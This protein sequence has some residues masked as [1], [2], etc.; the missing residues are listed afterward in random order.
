L[1]KPVS[2]P[3]DP[4]T[5]ADTVILR[6]FYVV[7][8]ADLLFDLLGEPVLVARVVFDPDEAAKTPERSM[9]EISRSIHVQRMR[10]ADRRRD[11]SERRRAESHAVRLE[12]VAADHA[13][14]RL[15]VTDLTDAE[16]VLFA[17]LASRGD[18]L[19]V[20]IP[21]ALDAGEAACVALAVERR[22]VLATDDSDGL[23]AFR[24]LMPKGRYERIRRM[25]KRAGESG[26]VGRAEANAIHQAMRDAGFWDKGKP[27]PS[28]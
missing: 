5:V 18:P 6:Y 21:F 20:G 27:F 1:R 26:L 4:R 25:L 15:E 23:T 19:N 3:D 10:S 13:L 24:S 16:T 12:Q 14:G 9:S 17:K 11:Q 7:G 28:G 2:P 8:Q 22:L